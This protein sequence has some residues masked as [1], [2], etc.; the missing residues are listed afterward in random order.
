M[1]A[2]EHS[3]RLLAFR[4]PNGTPPNLAQDVVLGTQEKTSSP[5]RTAETPP[6][7]SPLRQPMRIL[8][9]PPPQIVPPSNRNRILRPILPMVANRNTPLRTPRPATVI[10]LVP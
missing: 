9:N 10:P 4:V 1:P 3:E 8:R 2:S 7:H 6:N 5:G